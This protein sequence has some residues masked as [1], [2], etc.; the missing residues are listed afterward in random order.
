L[1]PNLLTVSEQLSEVVA[2][3]VRRLLAERGIS[4]NALAKATGIPQRTVANK[5]SGRNPFDLDDV[6]KVCTVLEVDVTDLLTWAQR[7]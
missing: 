6:A 3:E 2:A 5:L 1:C 7:S 4:G